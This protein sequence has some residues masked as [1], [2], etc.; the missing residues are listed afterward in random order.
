[1]P[2]VV[3]AKELHI[4]LDHADYISDHLRRG[5]A[6]TPVTEQPPMEK[7][8]DR[9]AEMVMKKG[10]TIEGQVADGNGQPITKARIY[11]GEYYWFEPKTPRSETNKEGRFRI[12]GLKPAGADQTPYNIDAETGFTVE[13]PGYAPS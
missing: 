8:F 9:T 10:Y 3:E 5:F 12:S 13:A 7:L 4:Y 6:P 2:A 11:T 1:M